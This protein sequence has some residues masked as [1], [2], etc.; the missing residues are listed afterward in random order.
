MCINKLFV[1]R[2]MF[3]F[4]HFTSCEITKGNCGMIIIY[5]IF[6]IENFVTNAI[7]IIP[8]YSRKTHN[9]F[10]YLNVV[11]LETFTIHLESLKNNIK[12]TNMAQLQ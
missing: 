12:Q 7:I 9:I 2:C 8:L 6:V 1:N 3:C 11:L 10:D 4:F 5:C